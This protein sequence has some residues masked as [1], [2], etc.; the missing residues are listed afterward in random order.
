MK[1]TTVMCNRRSYLAIFIAATDMLLA[2]C[3]T[4]AANRPQQRRAGEP[5]IRIQVWNHHLYVPVRVNGGRPLSFLLDT[6][7]GVPVTIID[8]GIARSLALQPITTKKARAIGGSVRLVLTRPATLTIGTTTLPKL[9]FAELPLGQQQA[10]ERHPVAGILGYD[11]LRRF[12]I[13]IDYHNNLLILGDSM[14]SSRAA[15]LEMT[16]EGKVP[17]ITTQITNRGITAQARMVVDSGE[18]VGVLLN[19]GFIKSHKGFL[20]LPPAQTGAG[21]GGTTR[22]IHTRVDELRIAEVRLRSV[23]V[24]ANLDVQGNL[25]LE[26]DSGLIGGGVLDRLHV[27]F[28]YANRRFAI[29]NQ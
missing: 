19:Y 5:P 22:N 12:T 1:N 2:G 6:G 11:F 25:N 13:D 20:V 18:D 29:L 28:D 14:P 8:S 16:L 7:A 24:V 4:S 27:F 17:H 23:S 21:L 10:A 26:H 3:G 15:S 9:S